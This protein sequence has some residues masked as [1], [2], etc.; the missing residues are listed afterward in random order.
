ML[1]RSSIRFR[2]PNAQ[3]LVMDANIPKKKA[4]FPLQMMMEDSPVLPIV[5]LLP[6]DK[7]REDVV[8]V[9]NTLA[10]IIRNRN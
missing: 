7:R 2:K 5:F 3:S 4:K 6:G 9:L 1:L 8:R 10:D